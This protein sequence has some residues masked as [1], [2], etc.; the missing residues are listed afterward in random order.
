[1]YRQN[2]LTKLDELILSFYIVENTR[3]PTQLRGSLNI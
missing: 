1:M 3:V 2:E